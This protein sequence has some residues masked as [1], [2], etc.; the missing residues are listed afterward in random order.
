MPSINNRSI[1][2]IMPQGMIDTAYAE[3][4]VHLQDS[5]W[6][7]LRYACGRF[8]CCRHD[9]CAS[10][11]ASCAAVH[12]GF[13]A[14]LVVPLHYA[15]QFFDVLA[16]SYERIYVCRDWSLRSHLGSPRSYVGLP[17][18]SNL[19][20]AEALLGSRIVRRLASAAFIACSTRSI[21]VILRWLYLKSASL[22]YC[23][24]YPLPIW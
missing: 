22:R 3:P 12:D 23:C 19:F 2:A 24:M 5:A 7:P 8:L 14:V 11:F 4:P 21:S 9:H 20:Y 17:P 6:E 15:R 13:H 10:G 18:M 16:L 1:W